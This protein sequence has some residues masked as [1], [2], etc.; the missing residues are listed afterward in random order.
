ME[1]LASQEEDPT[2]VAML[3]Y[4]WRKARVEL[5]KAKAHTAHAENHVVALEEELLE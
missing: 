5:A 3:G 2:V 4:H 1:S